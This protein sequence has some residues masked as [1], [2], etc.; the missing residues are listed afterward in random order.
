MSEAYNVF[1]HVPLDHV[2]LKS[3]SQ[4]YMITSRSAIWLQNLNCAW[5]WTNSKDA[6]KM[7]VSRPLTNYYLILGLWDKAAPPT[8]QQ[9]NKFP[10]KRMKNLATPSSILILIFSSPTGE[11]CSQPIRGNDHPIGQMF[12]EHAERSFLN[13]NTALTNTSN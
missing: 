10:L 7:F 3:W 8:S 1:L 9:T 6:E 5:T 11:L 12:P 2:H 13:Q 4:D